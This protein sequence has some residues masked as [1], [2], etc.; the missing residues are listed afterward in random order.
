MAFPAVLAQNINDTIFTKQGSFIDKAGIERQIPS[1]LKEE[2][3]ELFENLERFTKL[4][5]STGTAAREVAR[6]LHQ[7]LAKEEEF[8]LPP[9]GYLRDLAKGERIGNMD[10]VIAMSAKLKE[11]WQQMLAEHFIPCYA[12]RRQSPPSLPYV[13]LVLNIDR[14]K[15]LYL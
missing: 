3:K 8:A 2:H 9:L 10:E 13:V 15:L 1:S 12:A 4:S 5:G 6:V 7:H 11:D 14:H